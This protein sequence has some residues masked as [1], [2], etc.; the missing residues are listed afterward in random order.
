VRAGVKINQL[1]PFFAF[2][3]CVIVVLMR[4]TTQ[5]GTTGTEIDAFFYAKE[6]IR[7]NEV[8]DSG[9]YRVGMPRPHHGCGI[10]DTLLRLQF[11]SNLLNAALITI[12]CSGNKKNTRRRAKRKDELSSFFLE[13]ERGGGG[14]LIKPMHQVV[15]CFYYLHWCHPCQPGKKQQQE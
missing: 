1:T 3:L 9:A 4:L 6:T 7:H 14:N 15:G 13:E 11:P 10:L 2:F 8:I 5:S 12:L